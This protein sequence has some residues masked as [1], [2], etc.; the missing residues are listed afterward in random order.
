M[1]EQADQEQHATHDED[2]GGA[3]EVPTSDPMSIETAPTEDPPVSA[4]RSAPSQIVFG[5]CLLVLAILQGVGSF[6]AWFTISS[7]SQSASENGIAAWRG[8]GWM[9]LVLAIVIVVVVVTDLVQPSVALKAVT[10]ALFG[11]SGLIA[12]Y[13]AVQYVAFPYGGQ[14]PTS[15]GWGAGLCIG[16]GVVGL[17]L[18]TCSAMLA[19]PS[20]LTAV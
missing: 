12:A 14:L 4:G 6:F 18:G 7:Q 13:F 19:R 16:V 8:Y 2:V 9:T 17:A 3:L 5:L 20:P 15:L 10:A 11:A 1:D